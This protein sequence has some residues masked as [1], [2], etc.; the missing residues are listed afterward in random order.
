MSLPSAPFIR[1]SVE[2]FPR[3]YLATGASSRTVVNASNAAGMSTLVIRRPTSNAGL[4][5]LV[6]S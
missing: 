3:A 4:V 2:K 6:V 1:R 5:G